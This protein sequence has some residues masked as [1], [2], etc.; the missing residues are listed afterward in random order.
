MQR[1][2]V[3]ID[4]GITS[5]HAVAVVDETGRVLA[6]RR[7]RPRLDSLSA[8]EAT[9]LA[10]A[11]PATRLEVVIEPTG[12]AWL[13]V[14]VFFIR[15]GHTVFRVSTQKS[16]DL[17]RFLSRH[18]KSNVIDAE[19]LAKVAIIDGGH[20]CALELADRDR[21]ELD[22][23]VRAVESLT[24]QIGTH[25]TRI[26]D[27]ARHV[28]PQVDEVFTN[29]FGRADLAVLE[30]F[31][32]PHTI[33]AA[34]IDELTSF[35]SERSRH[36]HGRDRALA[37]MHAADSA[38]ELLGNDPAVAF[39]AIAAELA[40]EARLLRLLLDER[41]R[42]EAAREALY[43]RV[44]PDQ[45]ARSLPGIATVG[46][47]ILLATMGRPARFSNPAAFKAFTGLAPRASGT[48]DT[49]VKGQ[50]ISKAGSSRL[51]SQLVMS[52]QTARRVDPQLAAIYHRQ[53]VERG[54]H[55][56]KA[57]CVVAARLAERALL[58]MQRGEPYVIRDIDGRPVSP[59]EARAIIADRYNVTDEIRQ[60][61]RSRNGAR[62]TPQRPE[63]P[64]ATGAAFP[65][66][67]IQPPQANT[68]KRAG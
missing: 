63:R 16:A 12:P 49:D 6:R 1:R 14:A 47:P 66:T 65:A 11:E 68:V 55:H 25:K 53:I 28:I 41:D 23:R 61:R 45:L 8:I 42:H 2:I 38:I 43:R 46:A 60:R 50:P 31:G 21:A 29:K 54:A 30:H 17:R 59:T 27:L 57:L 36:N 34:G 26:R 40:S 64:D 39:D 52:A 19:T 33:M 56:T 67:T 24:D 13:P 32:N 20:L 9:A 51:R 4:L 35:I 18:A 62:K 48:G 5:A 15:R 37:W 58:V 7:C 22:R 10:G 3:G 44:D